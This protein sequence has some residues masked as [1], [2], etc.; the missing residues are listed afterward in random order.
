MHYFFIILYFFFSFNSLRALAHGPLSGG[1]KPIHDVNDPLIID[2]GKFAVDA[3]N[4]GGHTSL[5]FENVVKGET[6]VVSGTQYSLTIKALDGRVENKYVALVWD[7]PWMKFR[8]LL[9]DFLYINAIENQPPTH[10]PVSNSLTLPLARGPLSVGWKPIPDVNNPFIIDV[11]KFA[12]E[13]HNQEE[14]ISLKFE[15]VVK[16]EIQAVSGIKYNL[17]IKALDG[18]VENKYVA[19]VWDAPPMPNMEL[20]WLLS[21]KGPI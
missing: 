14:H 15:K 20:R 19:L 4:K 10:P 8:K 16:G 3:H 6:Q 18:R 17:T 12:V 13:M 5:K 9:L 2:I 7:K 21:F 1:W 11:G